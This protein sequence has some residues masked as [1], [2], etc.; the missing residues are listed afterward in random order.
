MPRGCLALEEAGSSTHTGDALKA[1]LE[2]CP[3]DGVRNLDDGVLILQDQSWS[4][5][6]L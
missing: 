6:M 5:G 4:S 1:H 2:S 3:R